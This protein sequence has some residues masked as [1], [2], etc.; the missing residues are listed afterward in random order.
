MRGTAG[1]GANRPRANT[2]GSAAAASFSERSAPGRATG[3]ATGAASRNRTRTES[4]NNYE[5]DDEEYYE[6]T[7]PYY[8]DDD[9]HDGADGGDDRSGPR[10]E[11]YYGPHRP[12]LTYETWTPPPTWS[13]ASKTVLPF[14]HRLPLQRVIALRVS[15]ECTIRILPPG[16]DR[17]SADDPPPPSST[18]DIVTRSAS[19]VSSEPALELPV[20]EVATHIQHAMGGVLQLYVKESSREEWME[21]TF[22]S[23]ALCA[24]FQTDLLAL[25][26]FGTAVYDMYRALELIHQGS[27]ACPTS[28]LVMHDRAMEFAGDKAAGGQG[29][30]STAPSSK[31]VGRSKGIAWDDVMRSLG[32][33]FPSIRYRLE[34]LWWK[35]ALPAPSPGRRNKRAS[36]RRSMGQGGSQRMSSGA[37]PVKPPVG[38]ERE[39]GTDASQDDLSS[40]L[41]EDYAKKRLLLGP[42]DFFRLFAPTVEGG[43][44]PKVGAKPSR[45]E[46]LLRWRKRVAR[47][48]VMVQAYV[49]ARVV[50]NLG[51]NLGKPLPENYW[52]R[53]LAFDETLDNSRWDKSKENEYYEGTVSRDVMVRVRGIESLWRQPRWRLGLGHQVSQLS[54]VQGYSLVGIHTFQVRDGSHGS[55]DSF[56]FRPGMDPVEVLPTLRRL[57]EDFPHLHFFVSCLYPEY[58]SLSLCHVFVF[59][60]SLPKGIDRSF[61]NNVR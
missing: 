45:V 3:A 26:L 35:N 2:G 19:A 49:E 60:R 43:A 40:L 31:T 54:P 13:E 17:S 8:W 25:Q 12:C 58:F 42:I 22:S 47:A 55:D 16:S 18:T 46:Q 28:E 27:P 7:P 34:A 20:Q 11:Y 4:Y 51:W 14:H 53:R 32:S 52:R 21:H 50:V 59:V 23:A 41:T 9:H 6:F 15:S 24:Q 44:L 29:G 10:H 30:S 48:S 57:I 5:E 39:R 1:G 36:A 61:D 33:S 37:A 38:S 56:P